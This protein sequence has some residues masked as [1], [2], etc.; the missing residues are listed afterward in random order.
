M[1]KQ[2]RSR[3]VV[4]ISMPERER[5]RQL[6]RRDLNLRVGRSDAEGY[7]VEGLITLEQVG[8]LVEAG[9]T[10]LVERTD[11]PKYMH[12]FIDFDEWYE[13]MLADL[14]GDQPEKT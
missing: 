2:G 4:V 14:E 10:V 13:G 5:L 7:H 9:Y 11:R 6:D 3:F 1:A 12:K 8:E